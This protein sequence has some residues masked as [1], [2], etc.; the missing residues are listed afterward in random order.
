MS[1]VAK[2]EAAWKAKGSPPCDH[3]QIA[4]ERYR[5]SQTGDK[6]CLTCGEIVVKWGD[7]PGTTA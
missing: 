5:G 4:K 2:I 1:E 6:V 7:A 3:P